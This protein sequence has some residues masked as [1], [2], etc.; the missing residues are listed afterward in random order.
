MNPNDSFT[1]EFASYVEK[2]YTHIRVLAQDIGPRGPTT[3]GERQGAEYCQHVLDNLGLSPHLEYFT[4]ARSIFQPHLFA[5]AAMLIV[6][7]I[8]P[9][10]GR[11]SAIIAA[12]ISIAALSSDLMELSFR[13]NPLRWIVSKGTSQNV[14]AIIPPVGD[15]LQDVVIIGHVD[16]QR[17]P[18]IFKTPL[19]L[20]TYKA[21]TT[22]AFIAFSAQAILYSLGILTQSTW[23][24]PA[25]GVSAFCAVLLA[26]MC[27]QADNT[28]FSH[29]ANDNAT[30][31]GLV[32]ALAAHF[33]AEMLHNTRL[34]LMCSGCEE[35]QHYGAIDFF[36]RHRTEL[37]NP[38]ALVFEMLGCSG[39]S[40][41]IKE[42]II[43]PFHASQQ[44][45]DLAEKISQEHPELDAYSSSINGG[46]TEM[47]DALR[48]GIPAI[49]LIGLTPEGEAP[50]WHM[51]E[52][53][54]DKIEP[55]VLA[56]NYAFT[57]H[58]IQAIDGMAI[59]RS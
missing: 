49:T 44:M 14:V 6:F 10:A 42:G 24:W 25:S 11:T 20:A 36:Q 13:P 18:I 56:R 51:A 31:A 50:Y 58:F 30:A 52:D 43:I 38:K 39:P 22:I 35:V 40:W 28:P 59:D 9:T 4:S 37:V 55:D 2:W 26:V 29:G 5:S 16:S 3:E 33:K 47:A 57:W 45:V 23:I 34:W 54:F 32:L 53:T 19:W 7:A 17:T 46:N 12:L 48:V 27:I 15:H 41:L 21:F 8:Y 1:S